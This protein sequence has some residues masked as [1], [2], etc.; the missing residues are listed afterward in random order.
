M[1]RSSYPPVTPLAC[2]R[3]PRAPVPKFISQQQNAHTFARGAFSGRLTGPLPLR[4]KVPAPGLGAAFFVALADFLAALFF[5]VFVAMIIGP[6]GWC[7][8]ARKSF[9]LACDT[10]TS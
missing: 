3:T 6:F 8:P 7:G 4:R 2:V 10:I 5:A 9:S 1:L